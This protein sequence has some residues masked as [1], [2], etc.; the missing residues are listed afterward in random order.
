MLDNNEIT[1]HV[2]TSAD[3]MAL[4][5]LVAACPPLDTNSLYCNLLQCSHFAATTILAKR[6][7]TLV[8]AI[9]GY[10]VPDADP[11]AEAATTL[12]VWQVAVAESARGLGLAKTMLLELLARPACRR[13]R[14]LHTSVTPDNTASFALFRASARQ[15]SAPVNET[16]WFAREREFGGDHAD[17]IL[18]EIGPFSR[19]R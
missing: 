10:L 7:D 11:A 2:P 5:A 3:G 15:L 9:S 6:R 16:L 4:H 17:E 14:F 1:F 12:F 19:P 18:L 8:G 13:T